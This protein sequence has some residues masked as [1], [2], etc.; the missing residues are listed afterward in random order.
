[1]PRV[2]TMSKEDKMAYARDYYHKTKSERAH[3]YALVSLRGQ[4]RKKLRD[5]DPDSEKFD[6]KSS[7]IQARI[8]EITTEL[9]GIRKERWD[10]KRAAG[11]ALFKKK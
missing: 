5:L 11:G 2:K 9:D 1:M 7:S 6:E 8:D 4:L 10:A 3:E